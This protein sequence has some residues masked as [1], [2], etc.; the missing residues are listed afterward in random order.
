MLST[1]SLTGRRTML[2]PVTSDD[3]PFLYWLATHE[4]VG[5]RWRYGGSIPPPD[6]FSAQ[7][8]DDVLTQFVVVR[9]ADDAPAGVVAAYAA[10]MRNTVCYLGVA[11]RPEAWRSL[12]VPESVHLFTRHLFATW[13]FRKLYG[14]VPEFNFASMHG[15]ANRYFSVEGV[16]RD[17]HYHDGRWWDTFITALDRGAWLSATARFDR[18]YLPAQED[19]G[20]P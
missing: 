20:G 14:E 16:L 9:R 3:L 4:D 12:I 1:V 2:R 19:A 18:I 7:L 17:D 5:F 10:D 15:G 8:W 11:F 6:R 13:P